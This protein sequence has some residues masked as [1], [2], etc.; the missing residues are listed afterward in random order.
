MVQFVTVSAENQAVLESIAKKKCLL[1]APSLLSRATQIL[2]QA[3]RPVR[4]LS[5]SPCLS[6]VL[7]C[8]KRPHVRQ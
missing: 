8:Y 5:G 6:T 3:L 7:L 2:L 1:T 4:P